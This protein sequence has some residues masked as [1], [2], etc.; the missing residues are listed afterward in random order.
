MGRGDRSHWTN[1]A[2]GCRLRKGEADFVS[3]RVLVC[4]ARQ[5]MPRPCALRNADSSIGR[6]ISV[7]PFT[8]FPSRNVALSQPHDRTNCRLATNIS[9]SRSVDSQD[10]I[11]ARISAGMRPHGVGSPNV[12]QFTFECQA[13]RPL[14]TY[15]IVNT[16]GAVWHVDRASPWPEI[17]GLS[18]RNRLLRRICTVSGGRNFADLATRCESLLI[19]LH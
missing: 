13:F 1:A 11:S 5:V 16:Q 7:A 4:E 8:H 2:L 6:A 15:R 9:R 3:D 14:I 19:S 10:P 12:W 17:D 18:K